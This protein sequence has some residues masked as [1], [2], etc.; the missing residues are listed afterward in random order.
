[1]KFLLDTHVLLWALEDAKRL[2]PKALQEL[3]RAEVIYVSSASI[4]EAYIKA[5]IGKLTLPDGFLAAVAASGFSELAIDW[6]AAAG[7]GGMELP[8]HDPFDRLLL[9]QADQEQL[10]L[11]TADEVLLAAHAGLCLDARE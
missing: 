1:M 11:V 6:E 7:I 3:R 10:R 8:H 9:A 2:G 5:D 4:W